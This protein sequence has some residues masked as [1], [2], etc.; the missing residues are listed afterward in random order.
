MTERKNPATHCEMFDDPA[1]LRSGGPVRIGSLRWPFVVDL[2]R[3]FPRHARLAL[4][5]SG[6]VW[7][8]VAGL[9]G[10]ICCGVSLAGIGLSLNTV[11]AD[12]RQHRAR[13]ILAFDQ[14]NRVLAR[15]IY[16]RSNSNQS[17]DGALPIE[18][19]WA[20][21]RAAF[22]AMCAGVGDAGGSAELAAICADGRALHVR[23]GPEVAAFDPPRRLLNPQVM[24]DF[25]ALNGR[26]NELSV[27]TARDADELVDRM[28]ADYRRLLLVLA[29][30][31]V[32]FASAG[33]VL[34]LL[35]GRGSVLHFEQWCSTRKARDLLRETLD[36]L[37]AGVVV[38]DD[39][40]RLVMF[41]EAAQAV[42]PS[43][44]VEGAIGKTYSELASAALRGQVGAGPGETAADRAARF[45]S[46]GSR[47]LRQAAD[48]RWIE[49]S[50]LPTPSGRTIGLRID[51][52][53]LKTRELE[54]D[55]SRAQF[56]S[57]VDSMSDMVYTIDNRGVLIFV[58]ASAHELLGVPASA[59]VGK[60]LRDFIVEED[61][62][63]ML[64][65]SR[66]LHKSSGRA[67]HQTEMRM[68]TRH[69]EIRHVEVRYR[70]PLGDEGANV[71]QVGVIRDVTDR[72]ELMQRLDEEMA[73]LRSIVE[74]SGAVIVL[75]DRELK[76]VMANR[77]FWRSSGL[78]EEEAIGKPFRQVVNSVID[79]SVF[80][81]WL[82]GPLTPDDMKPL[83]YTK[84]RLD[85]EGRERIYNVTAQPI[86][87]EVG[88][89]RKI[90]FL[91]V[92]DTERLEAEQALFDSERL[93]TVGEMAAAVA[94]EIAQPLQVIDVACASAQDE[95]AE[96]R[97]KGTPPDCVY[98]GERMERVT[99]QV[100]RAGRIISELRAFVRG[101]SLD[102][103]E[104]FDPA[105][106][107]RGAVDL[108][109]HAVRRA[110]IDLRISIA[111]ALPQLDGH[112]GKLEQV[113]VNL[114]NNAR[115]A[116]APAI[117]LIVEHVERDG[118]PLVRIAVEDE[119]SGIA[120][121]VLPRLFESFVTTK[122]R[123]KGTGLGLRICR[124]I[125]EEM[126]GTISAA[127]RPEGGARFE[128]L[129]PVAA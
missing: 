69:G 93:A 65:A 61:L 107:A 116:G 86:A 81:R 97:G 113:L 125:V 57:L 46:K 100:Q 120:P 99:Q 50:E 90:V 98:L 76:I 14:S 32:G 22:A 105:I 45:R 72:V 41:N 92:D 89:M 78:V 124:R 91:S 119:G 43:L 49:W 16:A 128:I 6:V 20:G 28:A 24:L 108:T 127:N 51:V 117:E 110:G 2:L 12:H 123:G 21:V 70:K 1:S 8:G 40:E 33:L 7:A 18:K 66:A 94:H 71:A 38:Y 15:S 96:A 5:R 101:T 95:L 118:R 88:M 9:V 62:P 17:V 106:A 53:N 87:D 60:R 75:I 31:T 54:I 64:A 30:S 67:V 74:S 3:S 37:P 82:A 47:A 83:R 102:K 26:L 77:E 39:Q 29:L 48:G 114:I 111:P 79:P 80:D 10:L 19:S 35:V 104:R 34:I 68:K 109:H 112:V 36:A 84:R 25:V 85:G 63:E 121:Q 122:E 58:S 126:A 103:P 11:E 44:S 59:M 115:D 129:L 56:Q 52:T 13:E 23:L 4:G 55:R 73:R 42:S 27:A